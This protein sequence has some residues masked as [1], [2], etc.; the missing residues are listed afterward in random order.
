[1]ILQADYIRS[2]KSK[3]FIFLICFAFLTLS[4]LA[5]TGVVNNGAKMIVNTGAV[6]KITGTGADYTNTTAGGKDGRIDLDGKIVIEGDWTNNAATGN[7]MINFNTIGTI[8]FNGSSQQ[9]ILGSTA[10]TFENLT[11]DNT[12]GLSLSADLNVRRIT[13]L[14]NGSVFLNSNNFTVGSSGSLSGSFG[15]TKMFV[16]NGTGA[17]QKGFGA[18]GSFT[19]PIGEINGIAEY[20][21]VDYTLSSHSGLTNAVLSAKVINSVHPGNT[22]LSEYLSRYWTLAKSGS[23]N[24]TNSSLVFHYQDAD[25]NGTEADIYGAQYSGTR[26][27]YSKV[28]AASNIFTVTGLTSYADFTGVDGTVPTAVVST[29]ES[30]PT[31]ADPIP[32]TIT[33]SEEV[34]GF[35]YTDITIDNGSTSAVSTSDNTIFNFDVEPTLD[36]NVTVNLNSGVAKDIA[37]N[38][39]S[40]SNTYVIKFD[41]TNPTITIT[42][43]EPNPTNTAI[44]FR[45]TFSELVTGF[46]SGDITV[47]N[48]S[49][50][51]FVE[52]TTGLVWDVTVTPTTE[53]LVT[54][55]IAAGVATD[56]AGN[57]NNI[58]AGTFSRTSDTTKPGVTLSSLEP[59]P[60]NGSFIVSI[61]FDEVV[62]GFDISDITVGNGGKGTFTPDGNGQDWTLQ[63]IPLVDGQ[64]TVDIA[65]GIAQDAATNTNTVATQLT[66]QYDGTKP[67]VAITS[68]ESNPTNNSFNVSI[69]FNEAVTGF[70]N[71]DITVSNGSKGTFTPDGNDQDWTLQIV[72][73]GTDG[74][75]TVNIAIDVAFDDAGNGNIAATQYSITYDGTNPIVNTLYPEDNQ[76][77]VA[78]TDNLQMVFAENVY[79]NTG[80]I[81]IRHT[82]DDSEFQTISVSTLSGNGTK[83]ITI[84]PNDFVSQIEYYVLVPAGAFLDAAGNEY[85]GITSTTEWSFT[86]IDA[87]N[88]VINSFTPTD[89]SENVSISADLTI[90][91]SEDVNAVA[92]KY[93]KVV[94]ETTLDME[95]I[96]A[97]NVSLVTISGSLVTI[98]PTD[99]DGETRYHVLI[100][101][102]AFEDSESNPFGG[103]SSTSYWNF[104]TE[105]IAVP[106]AD[107][108]L[109]AD[110]DFDVSVNAELQITFS[111]NVLA[112]TGS[113][114][115]RDVATSSQHY[116][117]SANSV[118]IIDNVVTVTP[119]TFDGETE[120]YV[121][122]DAD[123]FKDA[124]DNYYAG[125]LGTEAWNFTTE[126]VT[127]PTVI[128][129][130]TEVS[131]TNNSPFV[132]T[133]TFSE[134]I[135]N[136][137]ITDITVTGGSATN[138]DIS[139]NPVCT[140]DIIPSAD[141]DVIIEITAGVVQDLS[142]NY[143]EASD[144]ISVNFD[145]TSPTVEIT[146]PS[147]PIAS[148]FDVTIT[149]NEEITDLVLG[150]IT[151]GNGTASNLINQIAG[152][153]WQVTITP[154]NDGTV[155]VE[156]LDDV[157]TD[158]A[159]NG[160]IASDQ[161]S[162]EYDGSGP[163]ILSLAPFN[164]ETGVAFHSTLQITFDEPV[165]LNIGNIEIRY[166]SND[167]LFESISVSSATGEGT[168]T[169]TID[170]VTDFDSETIYYVLIDAEAFIDGLGN[171]FAGISST[172]DWVFTTEDIVAPTADIL[173][174]NGVSNVLVNANLEI[175][176]NEDVNKNVG[177]VTIM[178]ADTEEEHET[179]DV[180]GGQVTVSGNVATIDPSVTFV[181]ET[182]YYVLV[183]ESTFQDL[184]G[185]N[186]AG[187]SSSTDWI[188]YTEDI[189]PPVITNKSPSDN[190]LNVSISA[191]LI[192]TFSENV[193][194]GTGNIVI[195]N[196]SGPS[197]HETIAIGAGNV[198]ISGNE[199][200]INPTVDFDGFSNYYVLID[201]TAIE[202]AFGNSYAGITNSSEWNF[203]TIDASA[204]AVSGLLPEDNATGLSVNPNLIITFN[205]NVNAISGKYI[206]IMN[207]TTELAHETIDA[208]SANV[209][210]TDNI[211]T[212]DPSIDFDDLTGYYILI[213][214]GAFQDFDANS[215]PGIT[216]AVTWNFATGD[217][218]TPVI[219]NLTP[220]NNETNV[221]LASDLIIE[222]SENII[223]NSG[224]IT[225]VNST[226]TTTVETISVLS[227]AVTVSANTVTINPSVNF[228]S[229]THYHVLIDNDAFRDA[230]GNSFAG[231]SGTSIWNFTTIDEG[232][233][234]A[235][236]IA[237]LLPEDNA[238]DVLITA[239][240]QITFSENVV[241]NTG[242]I[243]IMQGATIVE[244][245]DVASSGQVSIASNVVTINPG[246]NFNSETDYYV[247]IDN[248]AFRDLAGNSFAGIFDAT[249]WNFT[250]VL[251]NDVTPPTIVS[252]VPEDEAE[253]VAVNSDLQIT[254]SENVVANTGLITIMDGA[255]AHESIDVLSTQVSI[256]SNVVTI[257]P[258]FDFDG[259]TDYHVLI[260]NNAFHDE[261]GNSFEGISDATTWNFT[262]A[263][264]SQP[265]VAIT[266][267][268]SGT[269]TGSFNVIITFSEVVSGFVEEDITVGNGAITSFEETTTGKVWTVT[270]EPVSDGNVTVDIAAG[271]TQDA[272]GNTNT[273]ATQ[274]SIV[275]D[276][277]VGVETIIPFE[278][279][280]Y[281]IENKVIVE[282]SNEGN[283]QFKEGLIEVYNLLG[284]KIVEKQINDFERFE[285]QVDYVTQIYVVKVII[286][287][288]DYSKRLYIE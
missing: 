190:A 201:P 91:F 102:G 22:S 174:P 138:L 109:P 62:T 263:D 124:S 104:T 182:N 15:S 60:T 45:V 144:P 107:S 47:G 16:I 165:D 262:T 287:G 235:P 51:S 65:A 226:T 239:N 121:E 75:I 180:S 159:G 254:F 244:S 3:F 252:L 93:I 148:D 260:E 117:V 177:I 267:T 53:G 272:A 108:F 6:L 7:V 44:D 192:I 194:A 247:L 280:I 231:I 59:D 213:E 169:I 199:I 255:T 66:R 248:D 54:V 278:I 141:G 85:A 114:A 122:I 245:I 229:N 184:S 72:P 211:V 170:P 237:S 176:F 29:T 43:S 10:T 154:T 137:D 225:I 200:T 58:L 5:Q 1:M 259:E 179:I 118:S 261:S 38:D 183:G 57:G 100:D 139:S 120:Y 21:P 18:V 279:S 212:I 37:G 52:Q 274:F 79:L 166:Q 221:A 97:S 80:N 189:E 77:G 227:T 128:L 67:T 64:V 123:A 246:I 42:S 281:S 249:Y 127:S 147:G 241:A 28:T 135:K 230:A 152:I 33:F 264:V 8:L 242:L 113:I 70:D 143:N 27:V 167:E 186:F 12:S 240:L 136:F 78:L 19:F 119:T 11:I 228:D 149:F 34:T 234:T 87:N 188:F 258:G 273:A 205:E 162:I 236:T 26:T 168:E 41:S 223:V 24:V 198:S 193:V 219:E 151:V 115:I 17:M 134:E 98:N 105:D 36:G 251:V 218:T 222:F 214:Y 30:D 90:T 202:D 81:E 178:N 217:N 197:I 161:F 35:A 196:A 256:A 132:I 232:D 84:N 55:N 106:T 32:F 2:S 13:T 172:S 73:D 101:A 69:H 270:I 31:N 163:E 140:V 216:D 14:T 233:I 130:T 243:K 206:T 126:D 238:T 89:E 86:T 48:G 61:F 253:G 282:F 250:T 50:T 286:D 284:Q 153:E 210:V 265:T 82:S 96:E 9:N 204:P 283:Y 4:A 20:C 268:V 164:G 187:I 276:S 257:N 95:S 76:S 145:S 195:M 133:I 74:L 112:G 103:I 277:G 285:T 39:N 173:S 275:Y 209:V 203:M 71:T 92:G 46:A 160:N 288:S 63:V 157:V 266:S 156:I 49:V 68:G 94:N 191:N 224:N 116:L 158:I 131:P 171:G 269:V 83:T 150:N 220:A 271:V 23:F 99:F 110:N 207:T 215:Y 40:A 25:I 125:I 56:A 185:N 129:S 88:P 111:E 181:G 208:G 146:G 155:T 175:T 142:D